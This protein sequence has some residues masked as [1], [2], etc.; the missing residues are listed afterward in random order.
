MSEPATLPLPY[1]P[2]ITAE[3]WGGRPS[4][5]VVD[6]DAHASNLRVIRSLI[7]PSVKLMAVVKANA[8]G[9][10]A[11][12]L[13]ENAIASGADELAVATVDEGAQLREA[14]IDA[15]IL[16]LG[17][18]G[19][20]ERTRAIGQRLAVV[21][22]DIGFAHALAADAKL[23]LAKEPVSIHL[24]ID[25]GMNRFGA[26]PDLAVATAKAILSHPELRLDGIMTHMAAADDP[27]PHFEQDQ[28][29]IFERVLADLA[30]A[31]VEIP[32]QHVANTATTLRFPHD[33]R[34]RVRVGIA[35]YGL[36]P[37]PVMPLPGPFK[38]IMTIHSRIARI[39]G[40]HPGDGVSYGF[41]YRADHDELTA[42]VPI[43]YADGLRRNLSP[44]MWMA[45][46]GMRAP[47]AG[48][49]CMDQTVVRLP[50]GCDAKP[51]D[52]VTVIGNGSESTAPAPT[53][54]DLAALSETISY[55]LTCGIAPRLP[56]IYTRGGEVIAIS[57]LSGTRKFT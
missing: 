40:I 14:G 38:R 3:H 16:V 10:G 51:G 49:I 57:D 12:I 11:E 13:G 55:E 52:V 47:V 29:A 42:L 32:T 46:G 56:K 48:R 33:H 28:V 23:M 9:H 41:R 4:I 15:P 7:G 20:G 44:L 17:P 27:D 6:L 45:V 43:G 39:H 21:I 34:S 8:Y 30:D 26:S 24:K 5:A 25:T 1:A 18:I 22:S 36:Q 19:A 31:G 2:A 50:E 53:F 54:D 37:D 35:Q